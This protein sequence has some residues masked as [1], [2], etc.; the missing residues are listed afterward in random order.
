MTDAIKILS[1]SK[2]GKKYKVKTSEKEYLF[3]ED[4]ILKFL[5]YKDKSF[6]EAEF[7]EILKYDAESNLFNKTLNFLSYRSRST[8]EVRDYLAKYAETDVMDNIISRLKAL[9]Y[10]NDDLFVQ[11][12]FD[13]AVR[14]FKG[15]RYL[16]EKL[17]SKGIS[18][19]LIKKAKSR[20]N[21]E[22]ER[23][24]ILNYLEKV[25][26]K[27]KD[28]PVKKQKILLMQK[29]QR[30]GF[31]Y[32]V[33]SEC[34]RK[35]EFKDESD[36]TLEKEILRLEEKFKDLDSYQRRERIIGRMLR[37]GYSYADILVHLNREE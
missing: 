21:E 34:I 37:A 23:E 14:N 17:K 27:Q 2:Q 6:S 18:S 8:K 24:L 16:E 7:A 15:P 9:G 36:T 13:Y 25:K 26:D 10:L 12:A 22:L 30:A 3:T 28:K 32:D 29:L 33:I 5:V 1:L 19:A 35:T 20:F 31:S 4:T 11:N